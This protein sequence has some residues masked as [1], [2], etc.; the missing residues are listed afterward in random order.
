M[1]LLIRLFCDVA[2][3][4]GRRKARQFKPDWSIAEIQVTLFY[5]AGSSVFFMLELSNFKRF[6]CAFAAALSALQRGCFKNLQNVTNWFF[7]MNIYFK[8]FIPIWESADFIW[9][10]QYLSGNS[11][12]ERRIIKWTFCAIAL[13]KL[14]N[15]FAF[16]IIIVFWKLLWLYTHERWLY[17]LKLVFEQYKILNDKLLDIKYLHKK[18]SILKIGKSTCNRGERDYFYNIKKRACA[19]NNNNLW[20]T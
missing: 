1:R 9:A 18:V 12:A 10:Q 13:S 17:I 15:I 5:R 2:R 3:A 16:K 14:T 20:Q 8:S 7:N 11:A 19:L 4:V 6:D